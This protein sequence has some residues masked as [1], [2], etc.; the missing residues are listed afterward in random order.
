MS[1]LG[2][3]VTTG[4]LYNP[5]ST[6][7]SAVTTAGA[8]EPRSYHTAVWTGSEMIIW[9]GY[10]GNGTGT[11]Y[12]DGGL[13]DPT[14]NSWTAVSTAGAPPPRVTPIPQCGLAAR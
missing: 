3:G 1:I 7:W 6:A 4:G 8:P 12:N 14:A 13:Y 2:G 5:S 9:G 11:N 10:N